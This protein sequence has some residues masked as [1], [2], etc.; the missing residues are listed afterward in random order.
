MPGL[1]SYC[2]ADSE[3]TVFI[4]PLADFFESGFFNQLI[5]FLL[6]AAAHYPVGLT[7]FMAG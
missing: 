6:A 1:F 3:N 2:Q 4:Y 5:H 7:G